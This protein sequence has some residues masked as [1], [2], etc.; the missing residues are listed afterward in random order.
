M[1]QSD[2]QQK[3]LACRPQSPAKAISANDYEYIIKNNTL[4]PDLQITFSDSRQI[5]KW[6]LI[7]VTILF[8]GAILWMTLAGITGTVIAP[9]TVKIVSE[10]QVIQH[11]EGGIVKE[12]L[13]KNGDKV[14]KGQSLL[15]ME[16]SG[17]DAGV[18][19][20]R[21][22][23]YGLLLTAARLQ[24]EK[25]NAGRISWPSALVDSSGKCINPEIAVLLDSEQKI[26]N[27][28]R[29]ALADSLSLLETRIEQLEEVIA[30]MEEQIKFKDLI[31]ASLDEEYAAKNTLYLNRFIDKSVV[32]GL[33][34]NLSLART[35]K[36]LLTA[37]I[38]EN[39]SKIAELKIR[40]KGLYND[41]IK[42]AAADLGTVNQQLLDVKERLR[43]R[44][45]AQNRLEVKAPV[46]G[47]VMALQVHSTGQVLAPGA[48]ILEIVPAGAPLIV[49]CSIKTTDITEINRGLPAD[50]QLSAFDARTT[51]KISGEVTY[52]SVDREEKRTYYG[53]QSYYIVHIALDIEALDKANLYISPGMPVVAFIN[54]EPRTVLSY[55]IDPLRHGIDRALREE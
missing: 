31:I 43:P 25:S 33:N 7:L 21:F 8:V 10:R 20:L 48:T 41:Y 28:H 26:F 39:Q 45:D 47:E 50:V 15:V 4:P 46:D 44:L 13:V 11:L 38:N 40:I 14:K 23:Q 6:G 36:E 37:G 5:I 35:D 54:I 27:S 19:M 18:K 29:K 2:K 55:A 30:S 52:I 49:E 32:L 34:R 3:N 1:S 9:G 42:R 24:A 12:I 17:V 16:S 53:M 51:P 22:R